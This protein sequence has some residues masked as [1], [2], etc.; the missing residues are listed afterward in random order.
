MQTFFGLPCMSSG[1]PGG[2]IADELASTR[3][4]RLERCRATLAEI[5]ADEAASLGRPSDLPA[6][7]H[8]AIEAWDKATEQPQGYL[9]L[10]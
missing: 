6:R 4:E 8:E 10:A 9:S 3:W 5:A 7:I 2:R 1:W